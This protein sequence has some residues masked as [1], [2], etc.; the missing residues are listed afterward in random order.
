MELRTGRRIQFI[1]Q[2]KD[3][4]SLGEKTDANEYFGMPLNLD[5]LFIYITQ[6]NIIIVNYTMGEDPR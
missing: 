5:L 3:A 6:V 1:K 2:V 4:F